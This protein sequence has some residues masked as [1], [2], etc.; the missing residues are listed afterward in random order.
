[1]KKLTILTILM[2]FIAFSNANLV[3][4]LAKNAYDSTKVA[5]TNTVNE[6]DTNSN[7]KMIYSDL[8]D[9]ISALAQ[10]LKVGAEHV[11]KVIVKQQIVEAFTFLLLLIVSIIS[12]IICYKQWGKIVIKRGNY[13][14]T[15]EEIRPLIFTIVFGVIAIVT[16]F[17]FILNIDA[18]IMGFFNPEY[19]AMKDI[20]NFVQKTSN[21]TCN[22]CH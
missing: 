21:G 1:M 9:G 16:F 12:T 17:V 7:F 13:S 4:D 5:V 2:G 11:Y 18:M 3:T 15:I 6:V 22:T 8:K 20:I 14:D 10:S 19:G